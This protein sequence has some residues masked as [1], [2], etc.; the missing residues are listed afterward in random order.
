MKDK[1]TKM[2]EKRQ[3]Q[4]WRETASQQNR[5]MGTMGAEKETRD[6]GDGVA[7][8]CDMQTEEYG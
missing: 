7:P 3:R 8:S 1:T 4:R 5:E 6:R 2:R